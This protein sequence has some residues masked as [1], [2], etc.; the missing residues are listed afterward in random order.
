MKIGKFNFEYKPYPHV[1]WI[2][3]KL[4]KNTNGNTILGCIRLKPNYDESTYQHELMHVFQ[5]Y[6]VNLLA[7]ALILYIYPPLS[8]LAFGL[9]GLLY[10]YWDR[11]RFECEAMAIAV[12]V[13]YRAFPK[14][15]DRWIKNYTDAMNKNYDLDVRKY[16]KDY[17]YKRIRGYWEMMFK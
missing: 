10:K 11:F 15:P 5:N 3:D 12:S 14:D 4:P 1:W 16:N 13:E 17:I 2:S 6:V 8:P 9:H 7:F